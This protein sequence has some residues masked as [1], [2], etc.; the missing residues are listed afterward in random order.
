[1]PLSFVKIKIKRLKRGTKLTYWHYLMLFSLKQING[2]RSIFGLFHLLQGKKSAQT[3]QD[4]QFFQLSC[5]FQTQP[6]LTRKQLITTINELIKSEWVKKVADDVVMLTDHGDKKLAELKQMYSFPP[7][8]DGWTYGDQALIFWRRFSLT[9]QCLSYLGAGQHTF[10]PIS[11]DDKVLTWVKVYL[12]RKPHHVLAKKLVQECTVIFKQ[13]P[14][15]HVDIF[16]YRL[17]AAHRVGYTEAQIAEMIGKDQQEVHILFQ[18]VLHFFVREVGQYADQYTE[19]YQ[20][21]KDTVQDVP[22]T[23][24]TLKTY[25]LLKRQRGIEDIAKMR[26]LKQATVE[27]HLVEIALNDPDFSIDP[28]VERNL[29]ELIWTTAEKTGS[30]RLKPIREQLKSDVSYFQI[31]LVLAKGHTKSRG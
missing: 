26:G 17:T 7:Y 10:I 14:P 29:Q 30:K 31:R 23:V 20:F 1:M 11:K 13:L 21:M 3:I 27:D 5:L 22:L 25:Q 4:S 19:L 9:T 2:E 18:S 16:L 24:S 28:Y 6:H 8:L 12:K 15:A